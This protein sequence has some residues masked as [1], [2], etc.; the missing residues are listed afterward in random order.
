MRWVDSLFVVNGM[1]IHA[2][3]RGPLKTACMTQQAF[4]WF[5]RSGQW[6][7]RGIVIEYGEF[8]S[9]GMTGQTGLVVKYITLH[10]FMFL[11]NIRVGMTNHATEFLVVG[12]VQMTA[13][14]GFP[15]AFMFPAVNGKIIAVVPVK[16]R[17]PPVWCQLMAIRAFC[18]K[19]R[20]QVIGILA[21]IKIGLVTGETIC[22]SGRIIRRFMA[23]FAI[24]NVM[25]AGQWEEIMVD[26]GSPPA[27]GSGI[28]ATCTIL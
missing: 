18:T 20:S 22:R 27:I 3:R 8:V 6:K 24:A 7:R 1:A 21:I 2:G 26:I 4:Q 15:F 23:F 11:S 19:P 16:I 25:Y 14:A 17:R 28:V 10:L 13:G 5:M 9:V 12:W